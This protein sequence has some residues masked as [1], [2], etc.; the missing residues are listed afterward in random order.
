MCGIFGIIATKNAALDHSNVS[1]IYQNLALLSERRGKESTGI[2]IK[3]NA[4]RKIGIYKASKK[5]KQFIQSKPFLDFYK[6]I[7]ED[8]FDK[9]GS[10]LI[11]NLTILGHTRIATNGV[12]GSQDNQPVLKYETVGVH[13]GIVCNV[14][15]L[16]EHYKNLDRQLEVDTELIVGLIS[17][18]IDEGKSMEEAASSVYNEIEGYTSISLLSN[19]F[20]KVLLGTNCGSLYYLKSKEVLVFASEVFMLKNLAKKLDFETLLGDFEIKQMLPNT[21]GIVDEG[22]LEMKLFSLTKDTNDQDKSYPDFMPEAERYSVNDYSQK[23]KKPTSLNQNK[24]YLKG[25]LQ[26][27]LAGVNKLRRCTKC[28]LPETHP[29]ITFDSDGICNY[30]HDLPALLK[31]PP[32][33]LDKLRKQLAPFKNNENRPECIVLLSGGRD[34]CYGLHVIAKELGMRPVAYSYDW[35]MLTELGRRNQS[36]MCAK[37]GIEHIPIS[38]DIKTKRRNIRMNVNA[39]LKRP[40]L[41]TIGLFMAGDK[42]F[43]HFADELSKQYQ[44][45]LIDSSNAYEITSFKYGFAGVSPFKGKGVLSPGKRL[46]LL[47]FY[48]S[49][50]LKNPAYLNTSVMDSLLAFRHYLYLKLEYYNTFAYVPWDEDTIEKTLREEYNW[51]FSNDTTTSWRIGDGTAALYNY[52][53]YT[54]AGFT[55]N[56]CLRSNQIRMGKID[57]ETALAKVNEENKPRF[58][59]LKWYCDVIELDMEKVITT[60]NK[61]PKMYSV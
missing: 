56:D 39:W 16:W 18:L 54:V 33:G 5:A 11:T 37:L 19:R 7:L 35:G 17:K 41:G 27:N 20:N 22:N 61:I 38:A 34:S 12:A 36:R 43:I 28:L 55:E 60:I 42:A 30:C 53:F 46:K 23:E 45:P 31:R 52:I 6:N 4:Q 40:H 2:A 13:N 48:A 14:E 44:L 1:D 58:E 25:L 49:Q 29:F 21:M 15:Q 3:N 24:L 9:N 10:N 51:E 32:R 26:Y 8:T 59:S 47:G 50:A 57:R